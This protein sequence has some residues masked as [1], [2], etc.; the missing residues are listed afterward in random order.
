MI[1]YGARC[2][3]GEGAHGGGAVDRRVGHVWLLPAL[4]GAPGALLGGAQPA[5]VQG[6]E[7]M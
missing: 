7:M 6:Q 2:A 3:G 1:G 5:S 4:Q